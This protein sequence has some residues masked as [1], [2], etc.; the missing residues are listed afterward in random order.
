MIMEYK[1]AKKLGKEDEAEYYLNR[2]LNYSKLFKS[3]GD[4][5]SKK[6][7]R[8]RNAN[9]DW[10]YSDE[11]FN[12][13]FW[14]DDYTETNAFNMAVSV[15]QDGQGLA[16]LYGGREALGEK[17]DT[18]FNTNGDYWGYGANKSIGGIHEQK[19]AREIK[20][21]QYGHSNQPSHHIAYMYNYAGQ[22]WKT[23]KYVRD[24]LKRIYIGSDFGQGYIME[25]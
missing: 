10:S 19:E 20:L 24:I 23:Q 13:F 9:G 4:D 16:N 17:I 15:T 3:T 14:G 1:L 2:A 8:G 21:G 18:I 22:P 5:V 6:W 25:K 12:P 7:L 11:D